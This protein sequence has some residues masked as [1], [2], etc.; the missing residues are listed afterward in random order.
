MHHLF[1]TF[2]LLYVLRF[3]HA[4]L[5]DHLHSHISLWWHVDMT[6]LL[7]SSIPWEDMG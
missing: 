6:T 2:I 5:F 1:W 3:S 4:F 7:N